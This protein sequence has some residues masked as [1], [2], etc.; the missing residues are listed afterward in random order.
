MAQTDSLLSPLSAFVDFYIKPFVQ[1]LPA[2]IKD[3]TDF[4]NKLASVT[5]LPSDTFL[6]TLASIPIYHTLKV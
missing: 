4:I 3:S 2:Y 5:D 1:A 6:L